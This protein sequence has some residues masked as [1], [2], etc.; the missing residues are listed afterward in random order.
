MVIIYIH[1]IHFLQSQHHFN[2]LPYLDPH[3]FHPIT[4][5]VLQIHP[6]QGQ[7]GQELLRNHFHRAP[8]SLH[9]HHRYVRTN[10]AMIR[11][12]ISMTEMIDAGI[13]TFILPF[14]FILRT[15]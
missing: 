2:T 10:I 14:D 13:L 1:S 4:P 11:T 7:R 12:D 3:P 9:D 15:L 5:G 8:R 6:Q